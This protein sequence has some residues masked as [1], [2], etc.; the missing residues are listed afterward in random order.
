MLR[1]G[2]IEW[3]DNLLGFPRRG[4]S[5]LRPF[6]DVGEGE[7]LRLLW[8]RNVAQRKLR[9]LTLTL[10]PFDEG[11]LLA[12]SAAVPRR[13][14]SNAGIVCAKTKKR[15][16][17][18]VPR[19]FEVEKE[20]EARAFIERQG[21]VNPLRERCVKLPTAKPFAAY[22]DGPGWWVSGALAPKE[23]A[24]KLLVA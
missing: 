21:A 9:F 16:S 22:F 15:G 10:S 4:R 19:A 23:K 6:G 14:G 17:R 12:E 3:V 18:A 2:G 1:L 8:D 13:L 7:I 24:T 11:P 20:D 5:S